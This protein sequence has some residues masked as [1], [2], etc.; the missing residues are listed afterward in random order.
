MCDDLVE[1]FPIGGGERAIERLLDKD[2]KGLG[3]PLLAMRRGVLVTNA[4][5]SLRGD[6]ATGV[7]SDVD[8][9]FCCKRRTMV[10]CCDRNSGSS[11]GRREE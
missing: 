11:S 3:P 6:R 8:W 1:V 9:C 2:F 4:L 10:T 5:V 7:G